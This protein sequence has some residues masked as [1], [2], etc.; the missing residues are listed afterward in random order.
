[1][2]LLSVGRLCPAKNYDNVPDITR[3][4]VGM[5]AADLR[6]YIIGYGG[7]EALIR[8]KI[9]EAGMEDHVLLLGKMRTPIPTSRR[10]TSTC[11]RR[12]TRA[13]R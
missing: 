3:R 2:K 8:Q 12:A 13:S 6:W 1:M 7:D 5:G 4:L 10:A 9:A 11:S